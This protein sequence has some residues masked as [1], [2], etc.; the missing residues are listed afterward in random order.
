ML[1]GLGNLLTVPLRVELLA[2]QEYG[3]NARNFE[4]TLVTTLIPNVMQ[5]STAFL[6]AFLFDRLH[7]MV[8]RLFVN[9]FILGSLFVFFSAN[10][11]LGLGIGNALQGIAMGGG[12]FAW[13]LWVTKLAPEGKAGAYMSVHTNFTGIRALVAPA[14]GFFL[15]A[16]F[17]PAGVM[18]V[19]GPLMIVSTLIFVSLIR[20]PRFRAA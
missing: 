3:F 2:N 9:A 15:L 6:W 1:M 12:V 13:N 10:S 20:H 19:A 8:Y 11:L 18:W 5:V 14:L 17:G 7:F 4:V 16:N